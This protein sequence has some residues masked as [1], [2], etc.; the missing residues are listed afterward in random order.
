MAFGERYILYNAISAMEDDC[1]H[2][3][4]KSILEKVIYLHMI[5]LVNENL[6]WYLQNGVISTK[7]ARDLAERQDQAVK[8]LM[9]H[10][11]DCVEALGVNK[12]ANLHGPIARDYVKFNGQTNMNNFEAAGDIF[13][14]QKGATPKD[15]F[16]PR[17]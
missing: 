9:P 7:A 16:R 15:Q 8:D 12:N 11:N 5:T 2:Q 6:G 14:F 13:D 10:I 3:G 1:V 4:A 17:M